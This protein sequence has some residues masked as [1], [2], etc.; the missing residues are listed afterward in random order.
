MWLVIGSV[1]D[2]RVKN[3]RM[4]WLRAGGGM[5]RFLRT[6][7]RS[8]TVCAL[9][10]YR[11]FGGRRDGAGGRVVS[12]YARR[13]LTDLRANAWAAFALS[14]ITGFQTRSQFLIWVAVWGLDP[15]IYCGW[16]VSNK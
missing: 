15:L 16:C 4:L 5:V 8:C 7:L 14:K 3:A 11:G 12:K 2:R 13:G 6:R 9:V 10:V 1:V